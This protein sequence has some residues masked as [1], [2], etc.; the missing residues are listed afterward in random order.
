MTESIVHITKYHYKNYMKKLEFLHI[1][2]YE[3]HKIVFECDSDCR[4]L[5]RDNG[6]KY[7]G[8]GHVHIIADIIA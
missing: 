2:N 5:A 7:T 3:L 6:L 8:L 4:T 1:H